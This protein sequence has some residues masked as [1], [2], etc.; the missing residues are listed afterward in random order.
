MKGQKFH[1]WR[2]L[3]IALVALMALPA[4]AQAQKWTALKNQPT[5]AA[6][7]AQ[8]LTDGR[9][10]VQEYAPT[11]GLDE[12]WTLTPDNTGSYVNGT[13]AQV[14]SLPSGYSPLFHASQVLADG[15]V[16]IAGGEYNFG[17]ADW[18]NLAAIYDPVTDAWTPLAAPSGW[19]N[20][21]DAQSVILPDGTMMIA[22]TTSEQEAILDPTTL[23]WT[24]TGTG[25]ADYNQEEGWTLLPDG[26]VLTVDTNNIPIE[27]SER[28][29]NGTWSSAGNTVVE[30]V[31]LAEEELGPGILRP[32][33]IV[34]Y[35]GGIG[36]NAIY[37]PVF[38]GT[39][40]W[41]A[42]P[43]F[44]NI[45]GQLDVADG[46]AAVL[47]DGNVLVGASPGLFNPPT[48]FFEFNGTTLTQVPAT[49][50]SKKNAT[51]A[52]RMLVL[53]TGQIMYTV[54]GFN[55]LTGHEDVEIYT[56][57]GHAKD[58]WRPVIRNFPPTVVAGTTY[59]LKGLQFNG[60]TSACGFGDDAQCSTSFPLV[61]ITNNNSGHVQY[62]RTHDHS[63]M[64]VATGKTLVTTMFDAPATLEKGL[65]T[66]E[67]V[68]NGIASKP[69]AINVKN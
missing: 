19:A 63:T 57:K 44:P 64:G 39:G 32:D 42:G 61:R 8:Q 24:N 10:L 51:F 50:H 27:N 65:S 38:G 40:T 22:N 16:V 68:A 28:W 59:K 69:A 21:G 25:K 11:S 20:I 60:L 49:P 1:G 36:N 56:A 23:T 30:L 53:P 12:F 52:G 17:T 18:T 15:R 2:G 41:A 26:S 13:W 34:F 14:A 58:A 6:N 4:I 37:T 31:A 9:I 46:P 43:T 54:S 48:Y 7:D 66:L 55:N 67:V 47:P 45:G 35:I 5:F 3:G 33:G 62:C 29:A